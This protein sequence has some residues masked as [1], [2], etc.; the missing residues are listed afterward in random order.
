MVVV[1]IILVVVIV[2]GADIV[3]NKGRIIDW[4]ADFLYD[5]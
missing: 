5:D 1:L 3:F 2:I 4:V